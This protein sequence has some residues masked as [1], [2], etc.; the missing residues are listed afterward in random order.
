MPLAKVKQSFESALHGWLAARERNNGAVSRFE[1]EGGGGTVA[2]AKA[3]EEVDDG[4]VV[5]AAITSCT[6]TSNPS[7][8]IGAGLLARNALE[9]GLRTKPWVKTSLAPGSKV[10]TDYLAKAGLQ[11]YLDRL[12]FNLVGYGCTTC[13][14]NSGP[15]PSDVAEAVADGD[16]IVAA[17]LSGNRNFEG[18]IHS[19]VR[20]NYLASPPLVVAY[21]LAGRIDA[22]LTSEP[23]GIGS[24]GSPVYLHDVWP[25]NDSIAKTMAQCISEEMFAREYADVFKGDENWR[26]LNVASSELYPWDPD[27]EYVKRPPYFEG[28][29]ERPPAPRDIHNARAIAVLGDSVTTDHISPAGSIG[30]S[31]PA[32]AYLMERGIE[33]RDFNSYGARR[34]NHEVMVR[35]TFANVRLRNALVPDVEGGFTRYLPSNEQ[36]SI[37]DAA[38]KYAADGTPLIVLAGKEYG[39]GSSRDWAAK[40]PRLL[41]IGAVIAESFER[42]HRSNLIGMGVLPLEYLDGAN[43]STYGLDGEEIYEI[44]GLSEGI[45][46]RMRLRVK[47]TD[48]RSARSI[49]FEVRLRVDTPNEAEYYRHG[50]ILQYVLRN[51]RAAQARRGS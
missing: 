36:L 7:V 4:S 46:P 14:G 40:G 20:A 2:T 13:I 50:G 21:A 11:Q 19:Q 31:S 30:R 25:S 35:G 51:L 33:P 28:M 43:R 38:R 1:N 34:G 18:R 23:L 44:A 47:A 12:G 37:F 3:I 29:P 5:I 48:P 26:E 6:N 42:I 16:L 9:R 8:L 24:D 32:G 10:V 41:G 45:E 15:L 49:E 22:D 39:S 27:S 17:V